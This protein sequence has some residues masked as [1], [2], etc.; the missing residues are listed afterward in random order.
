MTLALAHLSRDSCVVIPHD[1]DA[2]SGHPSY[3]KAVPGTGRYCHRLCELV[4]GLE[5]LPPP[6]SVY[7]D[8]LVSLMDRGILKKPH[9]SQVDKLLQ[10]K[11]EHARHLAA[12]GHPDK[13]AVL[14]AQ[15]S[16]LQEASA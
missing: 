4:R 16:A 14:I 2:D 15:V 6:T 13:A 10:S 9:R 12:N 8:W 11:T 5:P 3:L 7:A 1:V